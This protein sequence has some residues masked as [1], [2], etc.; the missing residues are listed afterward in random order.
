VLT[1]NTYNT[2]RATYDKA[3]AAL[4]AD[5]KA[6]HDALVKARNDLHQIAMIL[7]GSKATPAPSATATPGA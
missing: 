4:H 2:D 3:F 7:K 6:A 5:T 1:P